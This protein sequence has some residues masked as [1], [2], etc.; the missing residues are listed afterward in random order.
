MVQAMSVGRVDVREE[1]FAI[2]CR[3]WRLRP[4][5]DRSQR[6]PWDYR[7]HLVPGHGGC[8]NVEVVGS[9]F[10]AGRDHKKIGGLVETSVRL[11]YPEGSKRQ[12]M[13]PLFVMFVLPASL[14][15]VIEIIVPIYKSLSMSKIYY[16]T[17]RIR[18]L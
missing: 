12:K 16:F 15:M 17:T 4:L 5:A 18:F 6:H 13:L 14:G 8:N 10:I 7:T 1:S 2:L 3:H 9:C 11:S